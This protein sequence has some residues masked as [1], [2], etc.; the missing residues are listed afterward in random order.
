[1]SDRIIPVPAG[2]SVADAM[3]EIITDG[4]KKKMQAANEAAQ[5]EAIG[6]RLVGVIQ[7]LM[8]SFA[9]SE[10]HAIEVT[11]AYGCALALA[12]NTAKEKVLEGFEKIWAQQSEA[13]GKALEEQRNLLVGMAA[14]AMGQKQPIPPMLLQQ[15]QASKAIIP[16]E[17]QAYIDAQQASAPA[18]DEEKTPGRMMLV[19][20]PSDGADETPK[21][22]A[23]HPN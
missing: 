4:A 6:A 19:Q 10:D 13:H 17:I 22:A 8:Q 23:E 5:R 11:L 16:P 7:N 20:V 14:A 18:S 2:K 3:R 9:L 21:A 1:M 15:L 12:T